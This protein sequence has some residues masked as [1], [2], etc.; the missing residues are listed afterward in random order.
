MAEDLP[1]EEI[2]KQISE[3][4]DLFERVLASNTARLHEIEKHLG[5]ERQQQRAAEIF[6]A[7][8]GE[9]GSPAGEARS[10]AGE[11]SPVSTLR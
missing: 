10:P 7:E 2:L 5:V 1:A 6:A 11:I 4:L 9:V 3:R 8:K